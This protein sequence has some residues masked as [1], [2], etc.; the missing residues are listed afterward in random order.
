MTSSTSIQ[1]LARAV[2]Q[3]GPEPA[4]AS[5][6]RGQERS[7]LRRM[8]EVVSR[9][10]VLS[11]AGGLPATE[12]LP[13][14]ELLAALARVLEDPR[15]LQYAPPW[16]RLQEHVVALMARRGVACD[17]SRVLLTTGAQQGL[18]LAAVVL[19]EPGAQ[20]GLE[21]L[22]YPG[23]HPAV[24]PR[25]ARILLLA[26]D[27]AGGLEVDSL[28][29]ALRS[30]ARPAYVS[31]IPDAH[32]P[33]GVSLEPARRRRLLELARHY[34]FLVVED[35]PYG[36]L[37]CDGPFSPP[38]AAEDD[39]RTIYVGSLS[40]LLAP[41]LRL[42]WLVLPRALYP[43]F[44]QAKDGTD[45]ECSALLQRAVAQLLD[46][47][48]ESGFTARLET[49]RAAY[50]ARR[51]ALL[52]GLDAHLPQA[53]HSRPGGGMFVWA[54]LPADGPDTLDLLAPALERERVAF[55]PGRA[56]ATDGTSGRR[57]MRL[58]FATLDPTTIE[59]AVAALAR[60]VH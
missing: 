39:E 43:A 11:L 12:L 2:P 22:V 38:L 40:K 45:L 47:L 15:A 34:G 33:L 8:V 30:G 10:D 37:G 57:G 35:D 48:G 4:L 6:L 50:R 59:R 13:H 55:I 29:R 14:R 9:P 36:L 49:L 24:M 54:E 23:A 58:S 17:R 32:N 20:V 60:C 42:G 56:F 7:L 41:A 44:E 51:D 18:Q 21:R 5:W 16:I 46:D 1:T 26:S 52:R 25:G 3:A 27:L 53:R 19:L 28:E 31:V